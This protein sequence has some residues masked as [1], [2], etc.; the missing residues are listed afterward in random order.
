MPKFYNWNGM[1]HLAGVD[2]AG[3]GSLAGPVVAASV[4][5]DSSRD[6]K[7]LEDSKKLNEK[8]RYIARKWIIDHAISWSVAYVNANIIDEI[9]ILQASILA[10]H[11]SISMLGVVPEG[12]LID[13]SQFNSLECIP[14]ECIVKGDGKYYSIAAAS[15][16]AK[17]FRDDYMRAL[18]HDFP[19]YDWKNNKGYPTK[20]HKSAILDYGLCHYHRKSFKPCQ[21]AN[22][23]HYDS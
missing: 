15:I 21:D 10:M 23:T 19:Q 3:R 5:L 1:K 9:N 7:L 11:R 13:G 17:T 18:S 14:H 16:L 6:P 2:E 4:I 22:N 8:Q 12:L 20:R